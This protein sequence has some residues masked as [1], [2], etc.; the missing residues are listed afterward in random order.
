[1]TTESTY[2]YVNSNV[3]MSLSMG[4]IQTAGGEIT[5]SPVLVSASLFTSGS[6]PD[7]PTTQAFCKAESLNVAKERSPVLL[8]GQKYSIPKKT[9]LVR[10][11]RSTH[12]PVVPVALAR[13]DP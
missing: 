1:M 5:L 4:F 9:G 13:F 10:S 11:E 3:S 7:A 8:W 2:Q 6:L 12:P